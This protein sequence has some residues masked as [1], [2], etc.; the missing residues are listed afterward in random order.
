MPLIINDGV[1][2]AKEIKLEDPMENIGA[3]LLKEVASKTQDVAGDGTTTAV[4]LAQSMIGNGLKYIEAGANPTEI[5]KGMEKAVEVVSAEL[6]KMST[7]V[8]DGT[9][10][11]QV[12]TISANNDEKI[13]ELIAKAFEK[14]GHN[15]V[16]TVEDSKSYETTLDVVDGIQFDEGFVSPYLA[17]DPAKKEAILEDANIL[18]CDFKIDSLDDFIPVLELTAKSKRPLLVIAE[19]ISETILP[20]IIL[21]NIKGVFKMVAVKAPGYGEEQK[22]TLEDIAVAVDANVISKEKGM[23]LSKV[24]ES[25]FGSAEKIRI[26]QDKT[27]IYTTTQNEKKRKARIELIKQQIELADTEYKKERLQKRLARLVGGIAVINVGAATETELEEKKSRFDDALHATKAAI[28]EG[29]IP[30]GGISLLK[31]SQKISEIKFENEDQ[32]LGGEIIRKALAEPAKQIASNCGKEGNIIVE[33]IKSEKTGIG[34]NAKTDKFE[35]LA[36][37][38]VIDP[39]K[40][41]RTALQNAAS[42]AALLLTTEAIVSEKKK[43]KEQ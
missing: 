18:I 26:D 7:K 22:E 12:A 33:K 42:I 6:K 9:K 11:R 30:G 10:I 16:I 5:K 29:V 37:S 25:D 27:T 8:D 41:T 35:N 15:G 21:N 36:E 14:V 3:Q 13:G 43:T 23:S 38:G 2:I 39:T 1:T 19:E 28:E 31:A 20:T 24:Q 40:V 32:K 34:Y 17:T 4:V